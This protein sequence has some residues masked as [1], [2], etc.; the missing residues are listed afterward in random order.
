MMVACELNCDGSMLLARWLFRDERDILSL[1]L[2]LSTVEYD[3]CDCVLF[4][5]CEG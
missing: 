2:M 3:W 5:F 1:A 4:L